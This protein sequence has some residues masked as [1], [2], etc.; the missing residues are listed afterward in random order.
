[1]SWSISPVSTSYRKPPTA[2]VSGISGWARTLRT[3]SA[4]RRPLVLDDVEGLPGGVLPGRLRDA[5][6]QLV[7]GGGGHRAPGVR[8]DQDALHLQQ[9]D[10]EHERLEGLR[11]HPATGVAEDL[12]VAG[13]EPEHPQRVDAR[14]HAGDDGDAGMG[15]A[16]E[17]RR[18][19]RSRRTPCS[20]R[21]GRR[22]RRPRGANYLAGAQHGPVGGDAPGV[23]TAE[24]EHGERRRRRRRR[25]QRRGRSPAAARCRP[26]SI[27]RVY[28]AQRVLVPPQTALGEGMSACDGVVAAQP[29]RG[30]RRD[31]DQHA[32]HPR[33]HE[34]RAGR[35]RAPR[36]PCSRAGRR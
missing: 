16:V 3:S 28:S 5:L 22:I 15:D 18:G 29:D 24:A 35:R 12:G 30:Q 17:A 6:A 2:T 34:Q 14:V 36:R 23:G 11:G 10:A 31:A 26:A 20:P 7:E 4:E 32:D 25:S 9:V 13:L 1:M 19:R 8:D 27:S 33:H 21:A